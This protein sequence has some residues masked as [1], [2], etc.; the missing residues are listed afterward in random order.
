M[1]NIIVL[2]NDNTTGFYIDIAAYLYYALRNIK[3]CPGREDIL[4][5]KYVEACEKSGVFR[6]GLRAF[7]QQIAARKQNGTIH[8]VVMYTNAFMTPIMNWTTV[9]WGVMTWAHALSKVLGRLAGDDMLFDIIITRRAEDR[10]IDYP[11]KTFLRVR[12]SLDEET[13]AGEHRIVFVDDR[14]TDIRDES[15]V[16][17]THSVSAYTAA[18]SINEIA[19]I[20]T[21]FLKGEEL[22]YITVE[23]I[24]TACMSSHAKKG[25]SEIASAP[26]LE[27][28]GGLNL[29]TALPYLEVVAEANTVVVEEKAVVAELIAEETAVVETAVVEKAVV[30]E[31]KVDS[32][33]HKHN[34][35]RKRLRTSMY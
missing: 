12:D 27:I 13:R 16:Y 5:D 19:P 4:L 8:K 7:M 31:A 34:C 9:K 21:E 29:D 22:E 14:T 24:I 25:Y 11:N 32:S 26:D 17:Q 6:H 3:G 28:M 10:S 15:E 35:G 23:G 18:L 1:K 20:I 2:D 33:S 30:E